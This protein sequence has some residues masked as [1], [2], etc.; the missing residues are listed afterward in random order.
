MDSDPSHGRQLLT[1]SSPNTFVF[2]ESPLF[3]RTAD[4]NRGV[5]FRVLGGGLWTSLIMFTAD[6]AAQRRQTI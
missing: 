1:P 6:A 2:P 5:G 4:G 3:N